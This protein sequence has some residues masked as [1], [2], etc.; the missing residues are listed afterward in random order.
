MRLDHKRCN[1]EL[2]QRAVK[3]KS[4][5]VQH[6]MIAERL[7]VAPATVRKLLTMKAKP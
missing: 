2:R 7:G 3:L 5:G 6:K 1:E 4:Y